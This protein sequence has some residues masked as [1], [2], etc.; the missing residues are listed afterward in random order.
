MIPE[1]RSYFNAR[2]TDE[3]YR[4]Q[5]ADLEAKA[6]C[7]IE[8]RIAE[9]PV[10]LSSDVAARAGKLAEELI[11]KA[12]SSELQKIG[13]KAIPAKYNVP[14]E[15]ARPRVAAVDFAF[16]GSREAIEFKLIELQG[17]ASLFHYQPAF[18]LSIRNTY[19][20]PKE[21]NGMITPTL[22]MDRY[23]QLLKEILLGDADPNETVLVDYDPL[24]QKTLPD[25]LL[26]KQHL[27]IHVI[28][29]R[30][31]F[32]VG[33]KLFFKDSQGREHP[34]N[35]IYSRA[36]ADELER[37]HAKLQF[38]LTQD[39]DVDWAFHPNWYFR[40]S[41][42]L[43]PHLVGTNE[44]VPN[45]M[46]VSKADYKHL[47]LSRFVL[48][49]LYSF[50]GIG[51]NINP[52]INNIETIPIEE[53]EAWILQEK[54]EYADIITT[55]SGQGVRGELRVLLIWR[56][57]DERPIA[58]HTLVRLTRGKMIGV[59]FN[60]GLDWVGSSCALVMP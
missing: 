56:D 12:S 35:R 16:S 45:A 14:R 5:V 51:V 27:G 58:L 3:L 13:E 9:T 1:L 32:A 52:S 59:D 26:A 34:V 22:G 42:V 31:I 55:P 24:S 49:P 40:I 46:I 7:K 39:Y 44:A 48:K 50:A 21:L 20:L 37:K 57:E 17:F 60:K 2:F 8:F 47:D 6:G 53:Q 33:S 30:D 41:K 4:K 28:D 29:I 11:V 18:S 38:D 10:F 54:I 23:Y 15:H 25:F 19:D 36:I 43:L